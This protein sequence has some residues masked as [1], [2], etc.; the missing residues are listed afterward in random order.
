MI[1]YGLLPV[2]TDPNASYD[3]YQL[4]E[5]YWQLLCYQPMASESRE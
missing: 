1:R 3:P 4:N 2:D 5:K